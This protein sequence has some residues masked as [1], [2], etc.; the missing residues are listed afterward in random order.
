MYFTSIEVCVRIPSKQSRFLT[1]YVFFTAF[2]LFLVH[3][4]WFG[5]L[6]LGNQAPEAGG[7]G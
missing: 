6:R 5:D 4:E 7:T 3:V 2:V 1:F